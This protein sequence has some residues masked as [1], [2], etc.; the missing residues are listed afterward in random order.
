MVDADMALN[1]D[2]CVLE[3]VDRALSSV[4][5]DA[6]IEGERLLELKQ[7]MGA[8]WSPLAENVDLELGGDEARDLVANFLD[9]T[10]PQDVI[11]RVRP[12]KRLDDLPYKIH[13]NR[14]LLLMLSGAKPLAVF[15]DDVPDNEEIELIPEESFSP[16][17]Q[18]GRFVKREF[19][20]FIGLVNIRTVLYALKEEAWRID[21]WLLM[22]KTADKAGW[23]EGFERMEGSLLGYED[24][25]N[26]IHIELM[27]R[28]Q[29]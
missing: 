11:V 22:R 5:D 13:T 23:S 14:E 29:T 24:W 20:Y 21:A 28:R 16:Y 27:Y 18:E 15:S 26:D 10:P 12:W 7:L 25:Q 1:K 4:I 6:V 2:R 9:I 19:R 17:V 8:S 3:V